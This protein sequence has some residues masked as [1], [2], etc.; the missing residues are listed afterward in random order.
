[1][2]RAKFVAFLVRELQRYYTSIK[3]L[4]LPQGI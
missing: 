2:S 4:A 1:M 3:G